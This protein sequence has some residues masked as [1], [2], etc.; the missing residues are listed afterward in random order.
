M[1]FFFFLKASLKLLG[2]WLTDWLIRRLIDWLILLMTDEFV[3]WLIDWLSQNWLFDLYIDW[4][5]WDL[6]LYS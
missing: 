5:F 1:F 6:V 4:L 2:N 3:D